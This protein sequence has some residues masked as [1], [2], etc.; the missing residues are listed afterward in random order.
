MSQGTLTRKTVEREAHSL[1]RN[2]HYNGSQ[3]AYRRF[4]KCFSLNKKAQ[5]V[6][7]KTVIAIEHGFRTWELLIDR[8]NR[9]ICQ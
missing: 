6:D 5:V 2:Y 7:C 9:G 4:H 3:K 1:Y 8:I